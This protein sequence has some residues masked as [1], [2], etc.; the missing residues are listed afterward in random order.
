MR[1]IFV[2]FL[3]FVL[4]TGLFAQSQTLSLEEAVLQQRGWLAPQQ[5]PGLQWISGTHEISYLSEDRKTIIREPLEG[6]KAPQQIGLEAVN[7]ALGLEM[8]RFPRFQWLSQKGFYFVH[9]KIYYDYDLNTQTGKK[10]MERPR[11]SANLDYH[12]ATNQ[13]AYTLENNV[14]V[15]KSDGSDQAI[16]NDK[17]PNIV[18]GQAIA[19]YEFGI[20]KGTFWSPE[21]TYLAFYQKDE[22]NV[23]TY[24]L[25]DVTV[26]PAANRDIKYP[27][28]GQGSESA[29]IG[30]YD[31]E[32]NQLV[33]LDVSGPKDQYLTNLAWGP[34]EQY[35]YV[36]VVNREQ[37]HLW[38][39]QYEAKTGAFVKTLFEET[40][41]KYVE[42]EN[43]VWFLPTSADQFLWMSERDGYMHVYHYD[44][45]G[46]LLGQKTSGQWVVE[47]ILGFSNSGKNLI[48]VGT[49]ESGLN[50]YAYAVNFKNGKTKKLSKRT[51]IHRYSMTDDGVFPRVLMTLV[52]EGSFILENRSSRK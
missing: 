31:I 30:V 8:E 37:N 44:T 23:G 19:R 11:F 12:A 50:R 16:T 48:V 20:G 14:Y 4:P 29:K 7:R 51:G 3:V 36:A 40:H 6:R 27:M 28:A 45:N 49:D 9:K 26:T 5:I 21:A 24:T 2:L 41:D 35:L 1:N 38:L 43:P 34:N 13:L 10:R 15:R 39:N 47:E 17:D 52:T 32:N 18:S 42:P 25:L 22:T 33:Y 46:Q